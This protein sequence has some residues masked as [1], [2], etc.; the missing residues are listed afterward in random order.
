ME[1]FVESAWNKSKLL[2]KGVIVGVLVLVLMIPTY[3]VQNLIE[4][5]EQRQKE[6]SAEV[7]SKWASKQNIA[8]PILVL[9]YLENSSD[10]TT[11]KPVKHYA[12]FL[13]DDLQITSKVDPQERSRG[14][15]KVML[16]NAQVNLAGNFRELSLEKYKIP[17]ESV[18]WNEAYVKLNIS[19]TKGLNEEVKLRWNDSIL[20]LSPQ[21]NVGGPTTGEGLMAA[22]PAGIEGL[23]TIQFSTI[24][25][26]NGS[27]QILFTPVGKTTNVKMISKWENPSFTGNTLPQSSPK[28]KDGGFT[29]EWKSFS[30]K[31]AFA[32]HWKDLSF[33]TEPEN[34]ITGEY[35]LG[36]AA[37]GVNLFIPVNGYQKTMR[38]VKYAILCILLTFAAFFLIDVVHKKSV[39]PFQYGLIGLA[40]VLFYV[41]LLSFSEYIG[42]NIA[43]SIAAAATIGLIAWFVKSILISG[44]LSTILSVVLLFVY[45]YIFTILQLQDYALLIGSIGLFISLAIIMNFSR[46]IQW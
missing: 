45:A 30:H 37:F 20:S 26:I 38:S 39:H 21:I 44:K 19:D 35:N 17:A 28:I 36:N 14:I 32:Q 40:L 42:F 5:R 43:Y 8:G 12:F 29:A 34:K 41:L 2:V 11:K 46:K 33:T 7:S 24:L 22:I 4:E 25:N 6:A 18:L 13:P 31:R 27:E 10:N 3:Y 9:P 23:K 15:Y 1:T 16:Y